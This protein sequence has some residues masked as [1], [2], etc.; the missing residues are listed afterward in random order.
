MKRPLFYS[1]IL[2][3]SLLLVSYV[4]KSSKPSAFHVTIQG[5]EGRDILKEGVARTE[6]ARMTLE[7][8]REETAVE[9]FEVV[10]ARGSS[11][12]ETFVVDTGNSMDLREFADSARSGDRLVVDVKEVTGMNPADVSGTDYVIAIPVK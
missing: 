4:S 2:L 9:G 3:A 6:F 8:D 5:I 12:V 7:T 10:L 11:P 1:S